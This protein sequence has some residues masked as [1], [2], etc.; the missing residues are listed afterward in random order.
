MLTGENGILNKANLAKKETQDA[1]EKE[2]VDLENLYSQILV[3]ANDNAQITISMENLNTLIEN[4]VKD[5]M[6]TS[7]PTPDYAKRESFTFTD[8]SYTV[9]KDG[10]IQVFFHYTDAVAS[11]AR[12]EMWINDISVF[13]TSLDNTGWAN[14]YTPIFPVK[15]DDVIKISH[16]SQDPKGYYYPMR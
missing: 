2:Q 3:A 5:A 1:Q 7:M 10:Y 9:Q 16:R 12:D 11:F 4:K 15:K 14:T 6:K 8:N 13:M